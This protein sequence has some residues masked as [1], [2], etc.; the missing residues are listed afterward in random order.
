LNTKYDFNQYVRLHEEFL[1]QRNTEVTVTPN[2]GF[3]FFD[4]LVIP[5]SN[6]FNPTGEDLMPLPPPQGLDTREFGPWRQT[7]NVST[8]RNVAG[9]TLL[10]LPKNWFGD[11]SINYGESDGTITIQNGINRMASQTGQSRSRTAS[12]E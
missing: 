4:Q 5:A 8:Y 12:I 9:I 11:F 2:Q 10:N 6:P 3:N 7:T 1:F